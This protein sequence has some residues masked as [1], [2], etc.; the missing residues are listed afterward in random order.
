MRGKNDQSLGEVIREF[1]DAY[2]LGEKL[3]EVDIRA[4]WEKITGKVVAKHTSAIYIN[5]R[6]LFVKVDSAALRQELS[7]AR[8]MLLEAV[9]KGFDRKL[10]DD[11]VFK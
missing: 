4:R 2:K 3:D 6:V 8:S 7:M 9:N 10:V 5:K 11:V 1:V